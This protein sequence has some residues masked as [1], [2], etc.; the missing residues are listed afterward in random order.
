MKRRSNI[1][2]P[3]YYD[4]RR[5]DRSKDLLSKLSKN[6]A[7]VVRK[8]FKQGGSSADKP[9]PTDKPKPSNVIE[10]PV[11]PDSPIAN[12][13]KASADEL[14]QLLSP[15]YN[16]KQLKGLS[17]AELKELLQYTIDTGGFGA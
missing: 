12:W 14:K 9:K 4:N 17:E 16:E 7:N 15:I 13:Y 5:G 8:N 3:L 11:P 2:K 6:V 1:D 10:F